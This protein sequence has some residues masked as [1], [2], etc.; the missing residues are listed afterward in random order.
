[1]APAKAGGDAGDALSL[2]LTGK[3]NGET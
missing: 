1:L 3:S 2:P